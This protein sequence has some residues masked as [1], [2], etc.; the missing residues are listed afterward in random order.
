MGKALIAPSILSADFS[1]MG[2]AVKEI[3]NCGADLVH[4]DVMDGVFVPNITFG[5]K[6]VKDIKPLTK[7]PLDVHLMIVE[8][9]RYLKQFIDAGADY[10]TVHY[11]ACKRKVSDVLDEIRALGAKS[12]VSIKPD[13]PTEVLKDLIPHADMILLMSVYPGFGG[14][15]FIENSIERLEEI[16]KMIKESG[17]NVLLEIDGGV[18]EEN[19]GKIIKAGANVLVAGSTVF[20]AQDKKATINNLKNA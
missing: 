3:E 2:N 8:P 7:L 13:T 17:L 20:K 9:E 16:T 14:Q 10:L 6:M 4:C 5:I 11:E 19:A 12:A 1:A 18:T 15:K